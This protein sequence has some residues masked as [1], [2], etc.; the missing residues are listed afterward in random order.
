MPIASN[1]NYHQKSVC[2]D[3]ATITPTIAVQVGSL[4]N[5]VSDFPAESLYFIRIFDEIIFGSLS[6]FFK[7]NYNSIKLLSKHNKDPPTDN[8]CLLL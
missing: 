2:R 5:C 8:N 1:K 6:D 4:V 7:S 3:T